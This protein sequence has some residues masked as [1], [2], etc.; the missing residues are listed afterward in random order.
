MWIKD[1]DKIKQAKKQDRDQYGYEGYDDHIFGYVPFISCMDM[2]KLLKLGHTPGF[3]A[4]KF[5]LNITCVMTILT[6]WSNYLDNNADFTNISCFGGQEYAEIQRL[7]KE[8][9]G[10]LD[11]NDLND[12]WIDLYLLSKEEQKPKGERKNV[13]RKNRD[14]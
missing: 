7:K 4:T 11:D 13:K 9:L 14:V 2:V 5:N 12:I 6:Y 10:K 1:P 3:I 8:K